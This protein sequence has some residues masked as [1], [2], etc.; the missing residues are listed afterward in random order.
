MKHRRSPSQFSP[1]F[2]EPPSP[3]V[4]DDNAAVDTG[5]AVPTTPS[6]NQKNLKK[7]EEDESLGENASIS[8]VLFAN[9]SHPELKTEYPG[10]LSSY[11]QI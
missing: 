2:S 8:M 5:G 9:L 7:A 1:A 10:E 3:W 11:E 4:Q 6:S